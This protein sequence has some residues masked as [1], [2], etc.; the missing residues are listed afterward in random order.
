M[1]DL[2]LHALQL[3]VESG[4]VVVG[5]SGTLMARFFNYAPMARPD[6]LGIGVGNVAVVDGG[7]ALHQSME[8]TVVNGA[9]VQ[10]API[11]P[12]VYLGFRARDEVAVEYSASLQRHVLRQLDAWFRRGRPTTWD[13]LPALAELNGSLCR[14]ARTWQDLVVQVGDPTCQFLQEQAWDQSIVVH[15]GLF[16][17]PNDFFESYSPQ[18]PVRRSLRAFAHFAPHLMGREV[19]QSDGGRIVDDHLARPQVITRRGH[20]NG[21]RRRE[22]AMAGLSGSVDGYDYDFTAAPAGLENFFAPAEVAEEPPGT[23]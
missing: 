22:Q 23:V 5:G 16:L 17:I 8:E 19:T 21:S 20:S 11:F 15:E 14:P 10:A 12:R 6:R 3:D 1:C 9:D 18:R 2:K 7:L 4:A 13:D